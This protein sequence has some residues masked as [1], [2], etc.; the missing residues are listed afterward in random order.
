M[1]DPTRGRKKRWSYNAGERGRNWVRAFEHPRDGTFYLEWKE[2]VQWAD[3]ETGAVKTIAKRRRQKLREEDQSRARAVQKAEELAERFA[4][5]AGYPGDT[6][7]TLARLFMD[8]MREVTPRKGE[9]KQ[10]HDRRAQRLWLAYFD[11]LGDPGRSGERHPS[12]LDRIDWDGFIEARQS[13]TIPGW[14]AVKDRQVQYD[15]KFLIAV[16]NWGTGARP[17]GSLAPYLPTG[18]PW[19]AE[20]RRSQRWKMPRNKTPHR[21][22]MTPEIREALVTH[23][24]SWQFTA[25]LVLERDTR[26]RNSSIRRLDWADV[27]QKSWTIQWRGE[28]DK[29]GRDAESPLL[30][31]EAREV[32]RKA[33]SRGIAGPV[34]PSASDPSEPT[35]GQTFQ[36]WLQRAKRRFLGSLP[37]DEKDAWRKR[38]RGV[39]FHAEKR[40][41]VRDPDFR[42]MPAKYQETISGTRYATL[43][44]VYDE[45]TP[46]EIREAW[47]ARR[48]AE[49]GSADTDLLTPEGGAR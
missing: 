28:F 6:P 4:D 25:A 7:I 35:S 32:L 16:L 1:A 10:G 30:G 29:D 24:P 46:E 43:R 38:L 42:E 18:S 15:L 33:P 13:G 37:E 21:P 41:G 27:N 12:T 45:V 47:E 19:S 40:A 8:Y 9:G 36:T 23:S 34:F 26:R 2:I 11:G 49:S 39:G 5:L 31:E 20:I 14:K 48:R 17:N 44:D 3:P 22:S